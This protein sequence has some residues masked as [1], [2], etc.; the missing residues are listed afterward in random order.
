MIRWRPAEMIAAWCTRLHRR[1]AGVPATSF[2]YH[3]SYR[4]DLQLPEYDTERALRILAYLQQRH[5][6]RRGMLHRPRPASLRRLQLVHDHDYLEALQHPGA[7]DT[8]VGHTLDA[9]Q[10]DSFL[11]SQR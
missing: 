3:R 5:L 2:V 11:V 4:F 6:L 1:L 10:Q 8:I 7:L 9:A